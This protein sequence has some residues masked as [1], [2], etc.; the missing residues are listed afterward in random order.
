MSFY[1]DGTLYYDHLPDPDF[2]CVPPLYPETE[3][4]FDDGRSVDHTQ[5][6]RIRS[7]WI[8]AQM[9]R[10]EQSYLRLKELK[11]FCGTWNVAAKKPEDIDLTEWLLPPRFSSPTLSS[12]STSS[13]TDSLDE[14]PELFV[15]GFQEI[16]DLNAINVAMDTQSQKRGEFWRTKI[17]DCLASGIPSCRYLPVFTKH[18]VGILLCIFARD[19][20]AREIYDVRCCTAGVGIMGFVGNKGGVSIRMNIYQTSLC[21]VCSHLAAHRENVKGRNDDFHNIVEKTEFDRDRDSVR[22][23][24]EGTNP[25]SERP[26]YGNHLLSD[27]VLKLSEHDIIFWIGDL[28]YRID[29]SISTEEVFNRVDA[30]DLE[31]LRTMDQLNIERENGNVFED[32]N[33]GTLEFYP[34]YKYQTGTNIYERRPEKKLRAPSWCDRILW[35][36]GQYSTGYVKQVDYRRAELPPS[37]HKPV[38]SLFRV[39]V[40]IVDLKK[41]RLYYNELI[42]MLDVRDNGKPPEPVVEGTIIYL[43]NVR[44]REK[45]DSIVSIKNPGPGV[46]Y[47]RFKPKVEEEL[48]KKRW[49][50]TYPLSG[51]VLPNEEAA[52]TI[53]IRVD[54]LTANGLLDGSEF[55]HETLVLGIEN[56]WEH[57]VKIKGEYLRSCCG[58]SLEEMVIY[59]L[60]PVRV[61]PL[62]TE[63]D[64]DSVKEIAKLIDY[65]TLPEQALQVPKELMRLIQILLNNETFF[66]H[67][68]LFFEPGS[69]EEVSLLIEQLDTNAPF[70]AEKMS[71]FS[72]AEAILVFLISLPRPVVKLDQLPDKEVQ[73]PIMNSWCMKLLEDL[74]GLEENMF[75][76]IITLLR[77]LMKYGD[78][79]ASA[80]P[81]KLARLAL[82]MLTD[83]LDTSRRDCCVID[84]YQDH[85]FKA[86]ISNEERYGHM[87]KVFENFLTAKTL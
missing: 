36:E 60:H 44:Y 17:A 50:T 80:T 28:N 79:N 48:F 64:F 4:L 59:P 3:E 61:I 68:G 34:T 69:Q 5:M 24:W 47:W 70:T 27:W 62:P 2:S 82:Y 11:V 73:D 77:E 21:F 38:S 12:S 16:V 37:D 71:I 19:S 30:G 29:D 75:I 58:M 32:F 25:N 45:R 14:Y 57:Y 81:Q 53:T 67:E 46:V 56:G 41:E 84:V 51:V 6:Q 9:T 63:Q 22:T 85:E 15:I 23:P 35:K 65:D 87:L 49:I 42:K 39:K 1:D 31:Y 40:R 7:E 26:M 18:L 43:E 78:V 54:K 76:Y 10:K 33:E 66:Q 55:L 86:A 8:D 20:I 83:C 13:S 52:I 72:V 74:G